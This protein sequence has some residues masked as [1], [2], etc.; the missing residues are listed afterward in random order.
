[1]TRTL[2][3]RRDINQARELGQP[4]PAELDEIIDPKAVGAFSYESYSD[5]FD[6]NY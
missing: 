1:M 6:F 5:Y 2:A 3:I 4:E